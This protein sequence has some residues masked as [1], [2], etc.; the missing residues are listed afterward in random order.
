[1]AL[2]E[3]NVSPMGRGCYCDH[4]VI[5]VGEDQASGNEGVEG[6]D[7]DNEQEGRDGGALW[8]AHCHWG[9]HLRRSLDEESAFSIGEE[10]ADPS[11]DVPMYT[12]V[13]QGR[14]KLRRIDIVKAS[15]D[16]EEQGRNL[17]V[18][19]LE[20]AY[21]VREGRGSIERGE[22]GKGTG[23]VRVEEGTGPSQEG[24]TGGGDALHDLGE[25]F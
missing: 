23:L 6:G 17:E 24:Q 12:F 3:L 5:N 19:A 4:E 7:V 11:Y 2:Q 8:G 13:P 15:F 14:G 10:A 16:V 20:E 21:F 22:A 18:E 1:M 25:G 9:E